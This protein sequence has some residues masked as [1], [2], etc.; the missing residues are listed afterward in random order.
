MFFK[1]SKFFKRDF[2]ITYGNSKKINTLLKILKKNFS[3]LDV[4]Y[5]KRDELMPV[6]GTLDISKAKKLINYNSEWSL[7]H[8]LS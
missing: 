2:N 6:R 4:I 8:G 3:D 5:K 1:K 7:D